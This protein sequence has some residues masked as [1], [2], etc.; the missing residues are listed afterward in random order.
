MDTVFF[1]AAKLVWALIRPETVFLVLLALSLLALFRGAL[2]FARNCLGVALLGLMSVAV[3]P[4]GDLV[5]RPL[6]I[7]Y[8]AN[9]PL[10]DIAGIIVLGGGET[11][12]QSALWDQPL[13]NEA[14]D[15]YIAAILLARQY[16]DAMVL[17]TGGSGQLSGG[18]IQEAS[19]AERIFLGAGLAPERL[20][21]EHQSRNTA[22]NARNAF[23][24]VS[25]GADP[26]TGTWVLVTSASH[27]P[28]AVASFCAAGWTNLTPWPTDYQTARF[29]SGIGWDLAGH[30]DGLNRGVKEWVGLLAYRATGRI[31]AQ[32]PSD[33]LTAH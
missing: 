31:N 9:P 27:M 11:P 26:P 16:P 3:F 8:P 20:I 32:E 4:L 24:L 10:T 18:D 15:R 17:F 13:I 14:G 2:V 6:E 30:L 21:L 28:R 7:R 23:A 12:D 29:S 1:V 25:V 5:L 22:E 33:C 19:I